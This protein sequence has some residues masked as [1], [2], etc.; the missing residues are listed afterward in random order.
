MTICSKILN[1]V[2]LVLVIVGC[3]LLYRFGLPP[4]FDPSG[5]SF[6]LLEESDEANIAKGKRYRWWG[7]CGIALVGIGSGLQIFAVWA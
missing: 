6:L 4:A 5:A 3:I 7:R 2:G 1:S